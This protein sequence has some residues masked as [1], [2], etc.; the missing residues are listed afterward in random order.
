MSRCG[1]IEESVG[2]SN[3]WAWIVKVEI[4]SIKHDSSP[5]SVMALMRSNGQ[6]RCHNLQKLTFAS[7]YAKSGVSKYPPVKIPMVEIPETLES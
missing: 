1:G 2:I 6:S 3:D 5:A 4:K 7:V